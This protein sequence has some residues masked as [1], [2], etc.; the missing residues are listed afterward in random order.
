VSQ[1]CALRQHS[2]KTL[3]SI[4]ADQIASELVVSQHLNWRRHN[5][6]FLQAFS[7][8]RLF[9]SPVDWEIVDRAVD[10]HSEGVLEES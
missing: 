8:L 3:C 4:S 1:R 2:C 7:K 6:F 5:P 9:S 10:S